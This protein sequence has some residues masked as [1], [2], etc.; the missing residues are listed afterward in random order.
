MSDGLLSDADVGLSPPA[1]PAS[2]ANAALLS[3]AD[4]GI[5]PVTS[6]AGADVAKGFGQ[7]L[8][9]GAEGIV[10][11]PGDVETLAKKGMDWAT[12]PV[13]YGMLW[14][15]GWLGQK[16]GLLPAGQTP[17]SWATNKLTQLNATRE[18]PADDTSADVQ[19]RAQSLGVPNYQPQT[20]AGQYAQTIGSFIPGAATLPADGLADVAAN[21]AKY[22]LVPGVASEAAGQAT[23]GTPLE[24]YARTAGALVGGVG[25]DLGTAGAAQVGK[26]AKS[27]MEPMGTAGQEA[28]AARI[29]AGQFTD[30]ELARATLQESADAAQPGRALGE[31]ISGSKPTTGQL[32]ADP[33]ALGFE[34]SLSTADPISAHTNEFG[35]GSEQQNAARTSALNAIQ[36]T[37]SPEDVGNLVRQQMAAI[38]AEHDA[39]VAGALQNAKQ[40]ASGIG[41][42][43]SPE[44]QGDALRTTLQTARDAAKVKE[45]GL[46]YAVDPDGMLT[47]PA[48]PV[49]TAAND[50][51]K[52]VPPTAKP[53]AG[54]EAAIFGTAANLPEVAPFQDI[55]ALRS[56]I[57][58]AMRQELIQ[59]GQS[60]TYA[61]LGQ[62]RGAV[63][64]AISGAVE[65]QAAMEAQAVASGAISPEQTAD[66]RVREW[67]NSFYNAK[68]NAARADGSFDGV[69]SGSGSSPNARVSGTAGKTGGGLG[70]NARAQGIPGQALSANLDEAAAGRL[71]AA[72]AATKQRASTFDSGPVGTVLK[73]TGSASDYKTPIAA[74]PGKLFVPGP[75][76]AQVAE[77]YAKAAGPSGMN[78]LH[79]AAAES[80]HRHAMTP[81][82]IIDP[83]K[84]SAWHTKYQ[85]ALR[86]M[87]S[88]MGAKFATAAK[89]SDA[90]EE[91][92][93]ARKA[94]L[95]KFQEG[96]TGKLIGVSSPEDVTK[97]VSG[98]FGT[99]TAVRD[100]TA[101]A[102]R[103]AG[104]PDAQEGLRKSVADTIL[105]KAK[106]TT[107]NG[108]SGV[109]N[110]N[111]ST[112]QKFIRDNVSTI[113][114]AGFTDKEVGLM[115]AIG[116]DMQRGQ[117][118]LNATRLAGQSNTAQDIIKAIE[119]GH[120]P[121]PMSLLNKIGL[122]AA[123]GLEIHG[124]HGAVAGGILELGRHLIG[125]L[126]ASGL[127]KSNAL[128]RDA[129]LKPSLA[130][131]LLKKAP[132]AVGRGSEAQLAKLL[133]RSSMF[134][135]Y[136]TA[137][138]S[139]ISNKYPNSY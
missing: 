69:G 99:K 72:S 61:R 20:T 3:D 117:R 83:K 79:D 78:P 1:V 67:Q 66:A 50:I 63:E 95:D 98:I 77:S 130:L 110:L 53:M 44:A 52:S 113:K 70:N 43:T 35:T 18:T 112:F 82:G 34:R 41:A 123:A 89:A 6:S 109:E 93:T 73:K 71:K 120:G 121:H 68:E 60:P 84:F 119:A 38:Q 62:L 133:A 102:K 59:N 103:I 96:V 114:A 54:E 125:G 115:Q 86:A 23:A 75:Q 19:A 127:A 36:P 28:I 94:A 47:L 7:G 22:A 80:L 116:Q 131:A 108:A 88:T 37:G 4:V 136:Q 46:W 92:A 12:S 15:Q 14:A 42:G 85:D 49:A 57:S 10:G 24:P 101:L 111:A 29:L 97:T 76:G 25:A 65:N 134:S 105:A 118:T 27:Y 81:E 122:A 55:T 51:A 21:V 32:T 100:M 124:M 107:E 135:A 137:M 45:R 56:R 129:M 9:N 126:R 90:I 11:L 30:P 33:G 64:D 13:D 138:P 128:V 2:S 31:N 58:T 91:A 39:N 16:A 106:G 139:D 87:P 48:D 74:V 40:A 8:V 132:V 17:S 26:F 104:N 5:N